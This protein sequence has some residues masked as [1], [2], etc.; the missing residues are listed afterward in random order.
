MTT[1]YR[2]EDETQTHKLC[3][4]DIAELSLGTHAHPAPCVADTEP[5][6]IHNVGYSHNLVAH[7]EDLWVQV[8]LQSQ[9]AEATELSKTEPLR[10]R[11]GGRTGWNRESYLK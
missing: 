5:Q 10:M 11:G 6:L 4:E 9:A 7:P 8:H 3:W 2:E 1:V